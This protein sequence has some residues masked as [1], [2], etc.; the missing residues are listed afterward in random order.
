MKP[1]MAAIMIATLISPSANALPH[2]EGSDHDAIVHLS[3]RYAD[4][5][6]MNSVDA[7]LQCLTGDFVALAPDKPP[8]VGAAAV[9]KAIRKDLARMEI[10]ALRFTPDEIVTAGEWGF[11]RGHSSG[12]IKTKPEGKV[13]QL[14][15][16]FLWI[17][18]NENGVW[19]VARDSAFGDEPGG[20]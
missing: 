15:G 5:F 8:V 6:A 11:A 17:V 1:L 19:K 2:L 16:K 10:V 12:T 13:V 3:K 18:R 9:K 14:K 7:I 20:R 4:A